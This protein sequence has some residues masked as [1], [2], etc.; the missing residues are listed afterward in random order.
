MSSPGRVSRA[1]STSPTTSTPP[2]SR[3]ARVDQS[4]APP[5]SNNAPT[6]FFLRSESEME[7]SLANSAAAESNGREGNSTY[8]VQSLEDTL[9]SAF[10]V[11][12]ATSANGGDEA[13]EPLLSMKGGS[14]RR[15]HSPQMAPGG[16]RKPASRSPLTRNRA[17]TSD[18]IISN[19]ISP[20]NSGAR[21]PVPNSAM[22]STPRSIS[23]LS[24]KLSDEESE[25]QECASQAIASSEEDEQEEEEDTQVEDSG[26]L[27]QLV[28]PSIQ[29]PT[30]RPFT[31]KGKAMGKLKILIAGEAGVGKTSLIRSIVQLCEDIV[32]VDP[33]SP[34]QSFTSSPPPKAKARRRKREGL[35][36]T[37]ITEIHASTKALPHWWT[38]MEESGSTRRKSKRKSST[39]S[40]LERNITFVDTPGYGPAASSGDTQSLVV[41]YVESLLIQ[42]A[43]V[44]SMEDS[45]VLGVI[46]GNGGVQVDVVLYLLSPVHDISKDIDYMQRLSALTNVIPII[47]KSDTLSPS[48]IVAIKT[49]VLAR[50]QAT[51]VRPFFFGKPIEDALLAVQG[52]PIVAAESTSEPSASLGVSEYPFNFPTYPYAISTNSGQNMETMEASLL[53]SPDYVQPLLPSEL[54]TL[55]DQ[56]FDPDSI[57]WLRHSAARKF[58]SWRRRASL[59]EDRS[60]LR[61]I[62]Q[63]PSHPRTP[64]ASSVGLTAA[65]Q[66]KYHRSCATNSHNNDLPISGAS[67]LFSSTSPSGVLV[68]RSNSSFF[69][70]YPSNLPSNMASPLLSHSQPEYGENTIPDLQLSRFTTFAQGQQHL[71]EVRLAKWATDLQRSLRHERER[72]EQLQR[73][74]RAR[75]LLEKVGEEVREGNIVP[76]TCSSPITGGSDGQWANW[77]VVKAA[78]RDS[79]ESISKSGWHAGRQSLDSRDPLGLCR[80]GD[81]VRRTGTVLVKILGGVSVLGVLVVAAVRVSGVEGWLVP[82]GGVWAWLKGVE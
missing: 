29:M 1:L 60:P 51:T 13:V 43:S 70:N 41:D 52:L 2:K 17:K 79:Q 45:D 37:R 64:S 47:A 49:S 81:E 59:V 18:R 65:S 63:L 38:D 53:M 50:L 6:T 36:T 56:V 25:F 42:T 67:S 16:R 7:H 28:M 5:P 40:V 23:V 3:S 78:D 68:P 46:G 54:A 35:T 72:F 26:S 12:T 57:A 15:S 61:G 82:D 48:E 30:R 62:Q 24:L 80:L 27:P 20:F 73:T 4:P 31:T 55:V 9:N 75:W 32:H 21:S 74:E 77:A 58:L 33:L 22:P 76:M 71:A 11:G 39:D 66:G 69:S 34:S 8:G 44:A 19:P 14:R 10:G